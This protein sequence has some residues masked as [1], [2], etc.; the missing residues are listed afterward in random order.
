MQIGQSLQELPAVSKHLV[1]PDG[2]GFLQQLEILAD[3]PAQVVAEIFHDK[4]G[5]A[6]AIHIIIPDIDQGRMMQAGHGNRLK[7]ENLLEPR[8]TEQQLHGLEWLQHLDGH[9]L[10]DHRHQGLIDKT[11]A[12]PAELA[13]DLIAAD[14][15]RLLFFYHSSLSAFDWGKFLFCSR[16]TVCCTS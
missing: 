7:G 2:P 3:H 14:P 8:V 12:A 15:F 16:L 13:Q 11:H 5:P 6:P 4:K 1:R 10:V 9:G